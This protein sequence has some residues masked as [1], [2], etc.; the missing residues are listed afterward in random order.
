MKNKIK[1]FI[2]DYEPQTV[3]LIVAFALI[4]FK[5]IDIVNREI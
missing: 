1:Q 3:I 4:L 5:L 2:K